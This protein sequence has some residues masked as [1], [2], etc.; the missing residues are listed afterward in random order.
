LGTLI[1]ALI[2]LITV[3]LQGVALPLLEVFNLIVLPSM[4]LNLLLCVPMYIII[5]DM[6]GWFHPE[7]LKV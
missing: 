1:T 7:E 4:L 2:S 3:S 6:A 5:H